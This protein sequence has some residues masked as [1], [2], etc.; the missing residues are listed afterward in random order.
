MR[1]NVSRGV[2]TLEGGVKSKNEVLVYS[3]GHGESLRKGS[4]RWDLRKLQSVLRTTGMDSFSSPMSMEQM[5]GCKNS[6]L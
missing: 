1:E 5:F 3:E 4:G 6:L 2:I